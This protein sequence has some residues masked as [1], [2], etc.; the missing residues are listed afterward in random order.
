VAARILIV[1]NSADGSAWRRSLDAVVLVETAADGRA[2]HGA[3]AEFDAA[4]VDGE[5]V[6]ALSVAQ[7]LHG[8]DRRS[9]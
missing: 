9:R 7:H 3:P 8:L 2:V 5:S 4:L 1:G 6:E